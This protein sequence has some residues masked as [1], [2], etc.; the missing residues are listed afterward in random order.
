MSKQGIA[1]GLACVFAL[2]VAT[3][4]NAHSGN[5]KY[6]D[7]QTAAPAKGHGALLKVRI[8]A[9]DVAA[10]T[11]LGADLDYFEL[12][13]RASLVSAWMLRGLEIESDGQ[14]CWPIAGVP[15]IIAGDSDMFVGV[16]AE[17]TCERAGSLVLIDESLVA[18]N[19]GHQT[20][21]SIT[22]STNV[23]RGDDNRVAISTPPSLLSTS[24]NFVREGVIHLVTGY[25]HV[26]FLLSLLFAAGVV[27]RRRGTRE[28]MK[29]IG[30]V[31][32]AFTVGH[33]ITLVLAS[34]G[35]VGLNIQ[36]VE[37]VIAASIVAVAAMNVFYSEETFARPWIALVFG[38]IHGFG[39]SSV[40]AEVGLPAGQTAVA[41]LSFNIGIEL[42]QLAIVAI[43]IAP[44][45]W[46]AK[47][48]RFYRTAVM[49]LG[50]LAIAAL[51]SFWF[52]E[53][54]FGF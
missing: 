17:F 46:L 12:Q 52:V 39:F 44:L 49:R 4:V 23:L 11:G 9:T 14:R 3:P 26:L 1:A 36:F 41:L 28:A 40:L 45:G 29:E 50:S 35:I 37:S 21:V 43:T 51:A 27:A 19:D 47:Q 53:R 5:V 2:T 7:V 54:A 33:S 42:A 15:E 38:L 13:E 22:G 18:G 48:E 30:L 31:V 16:E 24:K 10:A 20:M 34:L 8:D 32:T 6:V 25:D